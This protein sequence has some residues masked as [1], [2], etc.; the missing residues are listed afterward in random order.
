M[1]ASKQ[2]TDREKS[3]RA[4]AAAA[5]TH[6][7]ALAV[8]IKEQLAPLLQKGES[9]PDVELFVRLV[10]RRV[11]AVMAELMAA[12][13]AH[14]AELADDS[15]PRDSRDE[16]AASVRATL[17]D[18]RAAIESAHGSE[19]LR[20]LG[21]DGAVPEDPSVLATVAD[22][23]EKK[24]GNASV[25][26]PAARRKGIKVDRD[27]FARELHAEL[28]ALHRALKDVAREEREAEATQAAKWTALAKNDRVFGRGATWLSATA[29][30]AGQDEIATRVRPSGRR[31][32]QTATP[33]EN[34]SEGGGGG[35][36]GG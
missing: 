20:L 31:P 10:G 3:T 30:L 5:S 28:P 32:G 25:K 2:V 4:V 17:V 12:D 34:P 19:G 36:T 26:L 27:E 9:M 21:L 23:V 1:S 24:L 33:D 16:A 8:G 13:K 15:G 29:A 35:G 18:L 22:N 7:A 14:E 6:A 11:E